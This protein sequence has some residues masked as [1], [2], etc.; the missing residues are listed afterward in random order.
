[1]KLELY[2]QILEKLKVR[3]GEAELL[4]RTDERTD[5]GVDKTK[6][7]VGFRNS[8]NAPKNVQTNFSTK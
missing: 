6:L 4:M 5:K 1:M 7:T 3:P 8:A 2:G